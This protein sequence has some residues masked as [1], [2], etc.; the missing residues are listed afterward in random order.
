MLIRNEAV[1]V[2]DMQADLIISGN[3]LAKPPTA[4][5]K[6]SILL[7][8]PQRKDGLTHHAIIATLW[9]VL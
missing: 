1:G 5:F 3:G 2:D 9:S 7:Q 4:L 8:L 6:Y